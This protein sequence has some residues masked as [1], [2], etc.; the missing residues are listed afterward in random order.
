[1]GAMFA[2]R[3]YVC[4]SPENAVVSLRNGGKRVFAAALNERA[5]VLGG[6]DIEPTDA[7][8]V[9]NEGKGLSK[10]FISLC[11]EAVIIP[12]SGRTESLN[13][14]SAA[15]MILWEAKRGRL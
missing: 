11:D 9:G 3:V 13:A 1:M 12:M 10:E 5:S 6:F 15:S 7:F 4:A 8:A 2:S 14:A